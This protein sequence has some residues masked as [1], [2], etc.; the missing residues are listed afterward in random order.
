MEK[1]QQSKVAT[2]II[3]SLAFFGLE[4]KRKIFCF[5][6]FLNI[7]WNHYN[8]FLIN[9]SQGVNSLVG[10]FIIY[11]IWEKNGNVIVKEERDIVE[12]YRYA[13]RSAS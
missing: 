3:E 5:I 9:I 1:I 8:N 2:K 4:K 12:S 11:R 6:V 7:E 13:M 10:I